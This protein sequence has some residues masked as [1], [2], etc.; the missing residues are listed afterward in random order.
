MRET[1]GPVTPN[2]IAALAAFAASVPLLI[3]MAWFVPGGAAWLVAGAL[4]LR[5]PAPAFRRRM[6]VLLAMIAL[7]AAAPIDTDTSDRGFLVLGSFFLAVILVPALILGRTDPGVIRFRVFPR[8]IRKL[9]LLY[10]AISIPLAWGVIALY[11]KLTPEMPTHW[12]LPAEQSTEAVW[13]LF[14]GINC[15]G[16]WDELFF[17]NTVFAV[18]RSI[19]PYRLANAGQAVVYASVLYDMAFTGAGIVIVPIFAWTQGA[20]FEKS[21]SLIWVLLVHLIVDFFLF[22]A[23][24]HHYYPGFS[25]LGW[26]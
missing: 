24:L 16:I 21:E 13:R 25:L 4:S 3:P 17:V 11:W 18:L 9:D 8:R 5:D 26:H 14:I 6:G 19:F 22:E 20:M 1:L 15:V 23:I 2:R 7:L 10:T 12:F